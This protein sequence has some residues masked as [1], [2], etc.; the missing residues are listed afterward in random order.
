M[1]FFFHFISAEASKNLKL[2][3]TLPSYIHG[4]IKKQRVKEDL[5]YIRRDRA[6]TGPQGNPL[7]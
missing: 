3:F 2:S 1:S 7:A 6:L 4:S 5:N